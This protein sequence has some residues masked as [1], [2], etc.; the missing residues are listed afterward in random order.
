MRAREK[1]LLRKKAVTIARQ[2][3]IADVERVSS[4]LE[5]YIIHMSGRVGALEFHEDFFS[6]NLSFVPSLEEALRFLPAEKAL[7]LFE[8]SNL[9]ELDAKVI[10]AEYWFSGQTLFYTRRELEHL[11]KKFMSYL[12]ENKA[13]ILNTGRPNTKFDD[14]LYFHN[15][16]ANLY[17]LINAPSR[18]DKQFID[19]VIRRTENAEKETKKRLIY[20][21]ILCCENGDRE[22]L[23]YLDPE[24][25]FTYEK[26]TTL[27][28]FT[29]SEIQQ[30]EEQRPKL[31]NMK[32]KILEITCQHIKKRTV[33]QDNHTG[34]WKDCANAM[35]SSLSLQ[36]FSF[37]DSLDR[38]YLNIN[39]LRVLRNCLG[40]PLIDPIRPPERTRTGGF[41]CIL[42]F[43]FIVEKELAT[44]KTHTTKTKIMSLLDNKIPE[45]YYQ[46]VLSPRIDEIDKILNELFAKSREEEE[47]FRHIFSE[48]LEDVKSKFKVCLYVSPD[49]YELVEKFRKFV[50]SAKRA[51]IDIM[52][53]FPTP[54]SPAKEIYPIKL[55]PETRWEDITIRFQDGENVRIKAKNFRTKITYKDMGFAD[56][57]SNLKPNQQWLFLYYLAMHHGRLPHGDPAWDAGPKTKKYLLSKTLKEYFQIQEDPFYLYERVGTYQTKFSLFPESEG[58]DEE[59]EEPL[60]KFTEGSLDF[61]YQKI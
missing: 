43:I 29:G 56:T 53:R 54:L 46:M 57:R 5:K 60:G 15:K 55:P 9:E 3:N 59:S 47:E 51:D 21:S 27:Y 61:P 13:S 40:S 42:D 23:T 45:S 30:L 41:K 11:I 2:H 49:K 33:R 58:K 31:L 38:K 24:K 12:I 7:E 10:S 14:S 32:L 52:G 48:R 16:L 34:F 39:F 18:K 26:N 28:S 8:N 22:P 44:R 4:I 20:F 6:E 37:L 25:M 35:S 50:E 17:P 36:D 1:K 19:R